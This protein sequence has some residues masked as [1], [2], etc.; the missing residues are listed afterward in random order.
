MNARIAA[1]EIAMPTLPRRS[2]CCGIRFG[3]YFGAIRIAPSRRITSPFSIGLPTISRT[4]DANSA[5]LPS[6]GGNGTIL[7]SASC[8]SAVRLA[9]IGVSKMPGAIVITRMPDRASSRAI[10][11]VMP[12]TP[13]FD[14]L[15][16]AWPICPSNAATDAVLTMTPR[17][18]SPFAIFFAIACAV[19]RIRLNVP[20]R[21]MLTARRKLARACGPSLPTTRSPWTMP[22]QLTSTCTAP[23]ASSAACTH[24]CALASSVTSVCTKRAAPAIS[25][26]RALPAS[27]LTSAMTT[28]PPPS[29][30]MRA[31]AAPRPDAPPVTMYVLPR[32]CMAAPLRARGR[33]GLHDRQRGCDQTRDVADVR[34]QD[35]RVRRLREIAE[36]RDVFLGDLEIDRTDAA[37]RADRIGDLTD[38]LRVRIRDREDRRGLSLRRVDFRLLRA[39][40]LRDRRFAGAL[41]DVDL[42]LPLAFRRRDH[43]AL[44]A[45]GG[46]LRLHRAQDLGGRRQVLDLVAQ[47]LDAPV[48]RRRVER[49]HDRRVDRVAL[50]E[51]AIELHAADDAAQRRLGELRDREHVVRRAVRSKPRIGDLVVQDAVD[52]QLRVVLRD[53]DLRRYVERRLAQIVAIRDAVEERN[54]EVEP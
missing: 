39:F 24:D 43:R 10:G 23:N 54:D 33:R 27:S 32:N 13:A 44:L 34:R 31:V 9:I 45:L 15:Y 51:R 30:A 6:R 7:P 5:G 42:L 1:T 4:S 49:A 50:L 28:R 16:A 8:T 20:T 48:R 41:R 36:L 52:L 46:D 26:A 2:T 37:L 19:R 40:R 3:D 29:T 21:L 14:A 35:H 11:S 25:C 17:S 53:A 38:R 47:H 22:A 18:P 12:T